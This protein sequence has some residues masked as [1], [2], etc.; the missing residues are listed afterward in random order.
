MKPIRNEVLALSVAL[1]V[2]AAPAHGQNRTFVHPGIGLTVPDLNAVKANLQNE[3]WA[4]GYQ[5]L[6]WDGRSSLSYTMEGP[7]ATVSRNPDVNRTAYDDDM[8]A[9]YELTLQWH[10]TG[11]S[12]Y[13]QKAH[14][15]LLAWATTLTSFGGAEGAFE[16][17]G[18]AAQY[19]TA[20]DILRGTWPGWTASDTAK[21][22]TYFANVIWP[23][24][25]VPGPVM[26]GSQGVLQLEGAVA[27]AI[28]N[29]DSTKFNQALQ[30]FLN[31]GDSGLLGTYPNGEVIDSGRDQGHSSLYM[32]VSAWI[33]EAF[34]DQGVDVYSLL[35]N[36]ILSIGE[37]YARYNS[38][39]P[40]PA[41]V[42]LG[43]PAFGLFSSLSNASF[44]SAQDRMA[45]NILHSHYAV[46]KGLQTP[47]IDRLREDQFEDQ[48]SFVYR[49]PASLSTATVTSIPGPPATTWLTTGLTSVDLNSPSPA[50]STAFSNGA[51]TLQAGY[52]GT[53]PYWQTNDGVQFAYKPVTGDFSFIAK[54]TSISSPA[55]SAAKAGLMFRDSL[56]NVYSRV[57]IAVEPG[58]QFERNIRGWTGLSY[59]QNNE[60]H[61]SP[62][63][64]IPF[65]LRMQRVGQRVSTFVSV[66]GANW[67]PASVADF[68]NLPSTIYVGLFGTSHAVGKS[69]TGTF[70][71]VR[72]TGGDGAGTLRVP[73]APHSI[74]ASPGVGQVPLRWDSAYEA[75]S[76]NVK[77]ST[78]PNGPFTRIATTAKNSYTDQS[79]SNGVAYYYEV[80]AVNSVGESGPSLVDSATPASPLV[81][82]SFDGTALDSANSSPASAF[83]DNPQS[84]WTVGAAPPQWVGY[85]FGTP[86]T[87]RSYG[88]TSAINYAEWDPSAWQLLGSN[89][90]IH[91]TTLDTKTGQVF[92]YRLQMLTYPIASPGAYRYYRL[93]ITAN[94]GKASILHLGELELL[95]NSGHTLANGAYRL[96]NRQSDLVL[97]S[98]GA[99]T[100]ACSSYSAGIATQ[101]WTLT[102]TGGGSYKVTAS[103]GSVLSLPTATSGAGAVLQTGTDTGASYQRW[104]L[105][106]SADGSFVL[107]SAAS[108]LAATWNSSTNAITQ[109]TNNGAIN[110]Q[111]F[112]AVLP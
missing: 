71:E 42:P 7:F 81:N 72:M 67:S 68:A 70:T 28:F 108:L 111:W 35:D 4:S 90:N 2:F 16:A 9:V 100:L 59:G 69:F 29:D 39:G 99:T 86:Q 3:P 33:A 52:N 23:Q 109:A 26:T 85:D 43:G 51:W 24:L 110:Q 38:L 40:Q 75:S 21:V 94:A 73:P 17:G 79:V 88:V 11:N 92:P 54:V 77:R 105:V 20:A 45:V 57:W 93:N 10:F 19:A 55:N 53:D 91:W 89:D 112:V 14:D 6:G 56:T 101:R 102:D 83:D 31:D 107:V 65:W 15:I 27:V 104:K 25:G 58:Y 30:A 50:G 97:A 95:A 44:D 84:G 106:P 64:G 103:N 62:I 47:W 76:Y 37:Y 41:Y 49:K 5:F 60:T 63:P 13:A 1:G 36:R 98:T 32:L 46:R 74:Y 8:C 61:V 12:A 80:T 48:Y 66:D 22:Q 82:I 87:I 96:M 18:A 78:S 34:W